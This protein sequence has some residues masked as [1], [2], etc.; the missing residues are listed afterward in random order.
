IAVSTR[1][2][3]LCGRRSRPSPLRPRSSSTSRVAA[4]HPPGKRRWRGAMVPCPCA[5]RSIAKPQACRP[6]TLG[7]VQVSE[8]EP[9]AEAEP[10]QWLWLTT[11]AVETVDAAIERVQWDAGRW[12][13]EVWHRMVKSGGHLDARPCQKAERLRRALAL[14]SVLAWRMFYATMRARAVPEA[15]CSVLLEPDAWPALSGAIHRVPT[16]PAEPPPRGQAVTWIAQLGGFVGRRR[17]DR[18]GAEVM[19]RGL[20]P[21]WGPPTNGGDRGPG[22][23]QNKNFCGHFSGVKI[24]F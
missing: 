11:V 21:P 6:G 3:A 20:S 9:P 18:P 17:S 16:P 1:R 15:P 13:M 2:N 23:S 7:A 19:W 12:G 10:I 4:H 22:F 5:P 24:V 14:S 8:V